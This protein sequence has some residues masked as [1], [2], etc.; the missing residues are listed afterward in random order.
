MWILMEDIA[1][2]NDKG[3]ICQPFRTTPIKC[4]E[5]FDMIRICM[6]AYVVELG[7]QGFSAEPI[8]DSISVRLRSK[9]YVRDLYITKTESV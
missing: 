4:S 3:E 8:T 2:V 5:S 7:T 1:S 6:M 9:M